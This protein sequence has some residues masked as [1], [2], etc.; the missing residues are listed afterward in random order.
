[1]FSA[2]K[3]RC[4]TFDKLSTPLSTYKSFFSTHSF[5]EGVRITIGIMVPVLVAAKFDQLG[6]GLAMALGALCVSLTDNAGPIHHRVNGMLAAIGF[7]L[8]TS[9]I[10]GY[11]LPFTWLLMAM[12][13]VFAFFFSIIGV[14]GTRAA[15]IG[16]S[17]LVAITLQLTD[18]P[19]TVWENALITAAGGVWYFLLSMALYRIRP[20]KLAQQVLGDCIMETGRFLELKSK[21][22]E[23][24]ADFGNLYDQLLT[25]Q[26]NVHNKQQ[27]VREIIF[28][29]RSIIKESTHTG[30]VLVMAFL[31]TVDLFETILT[32]EQDYRK[33]Q[34]QLADTHLLP[35]LG[36]ALKILANEI[37]QIGLAIQE[38]K[39]ARNDED[40]P[41]L[42]FAL[43]TS[44][45][46]AR[47]Q[48]MDADNAESFNGLRHVL[49]GIKDLTN[50]VNNLW[51]YTTYDRKL[52][53]KKEIAYDRFV[54]PSYINIRLLISNINFHSNIFRYSLRM[55]AAM[56]AGYALSLY[57]PVG[58]SYWIL[59]T[60]VV[61]LKPAYALTRQRNIERLLGTIAG[62]IL[63]ILVLMNIKNPQV[64]LF[65][66]ILSMTGAFS[67]MRIR[68]WASVSL[69]TLYVLVAFYL[70]QPGDYAPVFKD[71]IL[72]TFIGSIISLVFT[73]LIPPIWEKVQLNELLT[74]AIKA[75][76][77]YFAYIAGAF[78]GKKIE[79]SQYK[80]FRKE[81][82]VALANLSDAFQRMLNEPKSR[83]QP[84]EYLHPLVVS[85]HVLA[86]RIATLSGYSRLYAG[87][88]QHKDFE[89]L[90]SRELQ[91]L[92]KACIKMEGGNSEAIEKVVQEPLPAW[93]DNTFNGIQ[94]ELNETGQTPDR[95]KTNAALKAVRLQFE[96]IL[97]LSAD[98]LLYAE[99]LKRGKSELSSPGSNIMQGH[100][101]LNMTM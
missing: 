10:T 12:L 95:E 40:Y 99:K 49:N 13:A 58:H 62:G 47:H 75:N 14:F 3:I 57:L 8:I 26:I 2:M 23:P 1:M 85:C 72:D 81:T 90:I 67:L 45:E 87:T 20:Y 69:L 100:I 30:R 73:R 27:A 54:V 77:A 53:L 31:D 84:G 86:S 22:Y 50:R 56:L 37:E 52:K 51:V 28:K 15:S 68:Y 5:Y 101:I 42:L 18:S 16:T 74:N 6:W 17:V 24:D 35:H 60:I 11:A 29:T 7:I 4:N 96:A 39:P 9:L 80:W 33:L 93:M 43:E 64:L 65:I 25:A 48:Y 32:S 19:L 41:A 79:V 83:Q 63:G 21:F 34:Q 92:D 70:L 78:T 38:G 59:L 44:Y 61:I 76:S 71:R 88:V 36:K 98:I 97:I 89:K 55:A 94:W 46:K 82:Y 91:L 66:L